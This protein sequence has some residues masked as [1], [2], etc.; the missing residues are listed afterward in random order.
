MT[1]LNIMSVHYALGSMLA[2]RE[3]KDMVPASRRWKS[4]RVLSQVYK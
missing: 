4:N 1:I 3:S 2:I